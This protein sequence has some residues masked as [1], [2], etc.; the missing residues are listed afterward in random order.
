[1]MVVLTV[2]VE[3]QI[4]VVKLNGEGFETVNKTNWRDEFAE[5]NF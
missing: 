5:N 1:M 3:V 4:A 2:V